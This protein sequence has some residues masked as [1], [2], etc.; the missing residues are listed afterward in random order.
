[1]AQTGVPDAIV[2][3][4]WV[5]RNETTG[6]QSNSGTAAEA[7]RVKRYFES[8]LWRWQELQEL[9]E[10][11]NLWQGKRSLARWVS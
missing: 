7:S 10:R 11:R 1:M 2:V 9:Q 3:T 4:A 6:N 5:R 8:H